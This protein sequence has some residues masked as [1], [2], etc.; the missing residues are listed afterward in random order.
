MVP[1]FGAR[2]ALASPKLRWPPADGADSGVQDVTRDQG[3]K[4]PTAAVRHAGRYRRTTLPRICL[5]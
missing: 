2:E 1:L 5:S 3:D 4:L